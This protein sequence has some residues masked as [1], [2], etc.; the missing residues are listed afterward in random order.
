[1][2]TEEFI[3]AIKDKGF[4]PNRLIKHNEHNSLSFGYGLTTIRAFNQ[5]EDNRTYRV[6]IRINTKTNVAIMW[7][8]NPIE[9]ISDMDKIMLKLDDFI[10]HAEPLRFDMVRVPTDCVN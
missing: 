4:E 3:Q 7:K 8:W 1:M 10:V 5:R 2:N 6:F 9:E